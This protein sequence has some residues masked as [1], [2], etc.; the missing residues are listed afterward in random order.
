M[1]LGVLSLLLKIH[2]KYVTDRTSQP[3]TRYAHMYRGCSPKPAK[4]KFE[5]PQ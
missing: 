3:L 5:I 4:I 2:K 1:V